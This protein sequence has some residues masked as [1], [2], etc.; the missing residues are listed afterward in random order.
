MK[1]AIIADP[2]DNQSAGVHVYLRELVGALA[3]DAG[4]H[5]YIL[6]R[7]RVDPELPLR[8]IAVPLRRIPGFAS[9]RLFVTVPRLLRRLGVDAVFE[10]AHFG[11]FN[12]PKSVLR[13]TMIHDLTPILLPEHHRRHGRVLQ[14]IFLPSILRRADRVVANSRSTMADLERV[15][16]VTRGKI[17]TILLGGGERF[18]PDSGTVFQD[19][20]GIDRPYFLYVGTVEPRKNLPL[21]LV[22]YA[23]HRTGGGEE[24]LVIVGGKG[25]KS[26]AFHA[27]LAVHPYRSDILLTGFVPEELL[28]QAYTGS[29]ALIYPSVYEGFG[30]PVVEGLSCG[31][32]V[33]CPRNSSL[34]E[35]G[36]ELAWYYPTHDADKLAEL[37]GEVAAGG[38][39]V[40]RRRAAGPAWARRFNWADY[41]ERF[42]GMLNDL[43][44]GSYRGESL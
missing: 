7:Q 3:R 33:I 8:Q 32:S 21:L 39:E 41:A 28:A 40:A 44:V 25:W 23:A 17:E 2:L 14:R 37:L 13:V 38:P 20:Y 42:N 36:G 18:S 1:I 29:V 15:Y 34:P 16:P 30:F 43:A 5:E 22:A 4:G 26:E 24:L 27:A 12:L 19:T 11:P 9:L 31:T 35:V 6:I 10:P